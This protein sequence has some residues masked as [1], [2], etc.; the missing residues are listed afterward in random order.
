MTIKKLTLTLKDLQTATSIDDLPTMVPLLA[1][2]TRLSDEND[3]LSKAVWD[4]GQSLRG[5]ASGRP[6]TADEFDRLTTLTRDGTRRLQRLQYE[7]ADAQ[8]KVKEER[9]RIE[10]AVD[11]LV[12]PMMLK[13]VTELTAALEAAVPI[14]ADL[15]ALESL[16]SKFLP[17]F[18]Y[19]SIRTF[20]TKSELQQLVKY[21]G[22]QSAAPVVSTAT[23]DPDR[24][25]RMLPEDRKL[26]S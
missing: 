19:S 21:V 9:Q 4:A 13:K 22:Q 20:D 25:R 3:A 23:S 12:K 24:L 16:R 6:T 11:A 2:M 1:D 14:D 26:C 8:K 18:G 15:R 10:E 17:T 5:P 7:L